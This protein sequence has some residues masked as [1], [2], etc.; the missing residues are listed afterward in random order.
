MSTIHAFPPPIR[1]RLR[2]HVARGRRLRVLRA[3]LTVLAFAIAW[4]LAVG[5]VDRLT[6]LPPWARVGL[7][8]AAALV[9]VGILAGPVRA[10]LGRRVNWVEASQEI[11]RADPSLGQRLVT[12]TSQLLAPAAYRGSPQMIDALV[13]QVSADVARAPARRLARWR[14]LARPALLA[15]TLLLAAALLWPAEWL[16]LP[17]LVARQ[18]RPL[19]EIPPVTTTQIDLSPGNASVREHEPVVVRAVVRHP[20]AG[21]PLP[22]L[23]YTTDGREW[24]AA[25]MAVAAADERSYTHALPPAERDIRYYVTAGDATTPVHAL[26][27]LR[28]PAV[29]EFRVR[30]VYPAYTGRGPL[31]VRNTDGLIEAPHGTEAA[32]T[33][34]ATEPLAAAVLK[35]GEKRIDAAPGGEP[36]VRTARLTV[37][38]DRPWELEM[39]SD[40]GVAG[41]GPQSMQIRAVPDRP[42]L[43]RLVQPATDLRL[44]ERD[45]VPLSYQALDDYGV[46]TLVARAQ[47]NANPP[48]EYPLRPRGGTAAAADARRVEGELNVDLLPL[49]VRVGDVVSITVTATDRAGQKGASDVRHVLVSPRSVDVATHQRLAE[50]AQ[51]ADYAAEWADHLARAREGLEKARRAQGDALGASLSKAGRQIAA[52]QEAGALLRQS[53][54]RA[55]MYSASPRMSDALANL[56]DATTVQADGLDRVDQ[57][58]LATRGVDDAALARITRTAAAAQDLARQVRLLHHGDQAAAVLADR[59]NLKAAPEATA[60]TAPSD[61]AALERRRQ[62]LERARQDVETALTSLGVKRGDG[63]TDRQLQQRVDDAARLIDAARPVDFVAAARRWA[64]GVAAD[65]PYPP[66]L[67]DRLA[68]ASQAESVRPDAEL[69]AARDL[70]LASRAAALLTAEPPIEGDGLSAAKER[71]A[72]L[73]TFP[74]A[75]AALRAEHDVNRRALRAATLAEARKVQEAARDVHAAASAARA[76]MVAWASG[77]GATA[78]ELA[79]RAKEAEELA[80]AANAATA[81]REFDKAAELDRRLATSLNRPDLADASAA[82]RAI[83]DLSLHQEKVADDLADSG[84]ADA[85]RA[86]AIAGVQRQVADEIGAAKAADPAAVGGG[87]ADADA[88]ADSAEARRRATEA[89]TRAQETLA[90]LPMQLA[91]AQQLA[92]ATADAN[93]RLAAARAEA[94][95]APAARQETAS[96]VA[97]MVRAEA[98]E[99]RRTFDAAVAPF[100]GSLADEVADA[101][102]PLGPDAAAA[103]GVADDALRSV[104]ADARDVLSRS[105]ETGDRAGVEVA[106]QAARDA[107]AQVQEAL[108]DAQQRVIERDPLV[109]AKW[110]ARAAADA[111]AAAPPNRGKAAGHQKRTLEAL[112][113]AAVDAVRRSK[114]ARLSNVPSYAPF[115]VPP[116]GGAWTDAAAG[117]SQDGVRRGGA[118]GSAAD[119]LLQ[120][121]PGLREWGRLRERAAESL[122]AP[123]RE[124]D[125]PGYSD[126][127]RTYFEVLGREEA[128]P[129]GAK[130]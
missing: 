48:V 40:R 105:A 6:A 98:E 7:L 59:A 125:P 75:I 94:A 107:V 55:T 93:S 46:A 89:I 119:R 45:L 18:L 103:A 78:G 36:N 110:F 21:G 52:A 116:L 123:V 61:K 91:D 111:L 1:R 34:V 130:P 11:E 108:R 27:V 122:A 80:L 3:G 104:L 58:V 84:S 22:T 38:N 79:A 124:S 67:A 57:A 113:R 68:A 127:L 2:D 31:S 47:V 76:K 10:A 73:A 112:N 63:T 92:E 69:V 114:N 126:A 51:A 53:L 64:A 29:A 115:Y 44:A 99:A 86:T 102:R 26:R 14:P 88:D 20:T 65:E 60:S 30:Y 129:P 16:N 100:K 12:V 42:P 35:I 97:A 25:P 54:L 62:T 28:R 49:K 15:A 50:L 101:L 19:S 128:R 85:S 90:Q 33:I 96:R 4:A 70:Q 66:H 106:A 37:D 41:G 32:V 17:Q 39:T 87:A 82:P 120:A 121:I 23:H 24:D 13:E 81:T 117:D 83:D 56:V 118:G 77:P 109:S 8:S 71:A 5:V 74:D 9:A 72:A 43:V 95:K